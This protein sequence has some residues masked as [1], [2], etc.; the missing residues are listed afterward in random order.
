MIHALFGHGLGN[1]FQDNSL[2]EII[3]SYNQRSALVIVCIIE[4][5]GLTAYTINDTVITECH[6]QIAGRFGEYNSISVAQVNLII[7]PMT[8]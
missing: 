3:K 4:H 1:Q 5:G 2:F 6:Y 8:A 7:Y